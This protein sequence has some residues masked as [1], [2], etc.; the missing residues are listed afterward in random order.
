M[1]MDRTL[2]MCNIIILLS[3]LYYTKDGLNKQIILIQISA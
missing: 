2:E 3:S 1:K